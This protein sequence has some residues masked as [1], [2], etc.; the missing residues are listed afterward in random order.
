MRYMLDTNI[1]IY[2]IKHKPPEVIQR[3]LSHD[4]SELCISSITYAELMHGVEKSMAAERNRIAI[5]MFLSPISVLNF[6]TYAAEEYGKIRADLERKGIPIGPMDILIAAHAKA[7]DLILVTNN[8]REFERVED[9][10][11]EDWT[12]E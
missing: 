12:K 1:C 2:T 3:F 4:P 8:T 6:D 11:V 5:T 10:D 9:L 7:E